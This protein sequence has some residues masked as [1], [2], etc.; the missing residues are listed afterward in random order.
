MKW[1]KAKRGPSE[2]AQNR[3]SRQQA[4]RDLEKK[5]TK[6]KRS[7]IKQLREA[8][9]LAKT[10]A[11]AEC[12]HRRENARLMSKE[13]IRE[14]R[15]ELQADLQ[16]LGDECQS[17]MASKTTP[18]VGSIEELA[19]ELRSSAMAQKHS[20]QREAARPRESGRETLERE[21][22][23]VRADIGK[24][25]F[26]LPIFERLKR[27]LRR[28]PRQTLT[29]AFRELVAETPELVAEEQARASRMMSDLD[30]N[31]AEAKHLAKQGDESA[32]Q[33]ATDN[34]QRRRPKGSAKSRTLGLYG[35]DLIPSDT[36]PKPPEPRGKKPRSSTSTKG[37]QSLA[38]G[39]LGG[40]IL[41]DPPF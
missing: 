8:L 4:V 34:C 3:R 25:P 24:E 15:A 21:F 20:R 28:G 40:S 27:S 36:R 7:R 41:E 35:P 31:C 9:K 16:R 5:A 18:I 13:G 37:Q 17:R 14:V 1:K 23:Q 33:W 12:K 32:E 38:G 6:E 39:P 11:R 22:D 26:L 2:E 30:R 29:E 10:Q 19:T